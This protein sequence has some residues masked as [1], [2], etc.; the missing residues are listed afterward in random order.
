MKLQDLLAETAQKF[1]SCG[2][3]SAQADA[4]I[5]LSF[6]LQ[7]ARGDLLARAITGAEI[8]ET[9]LRRFL[10]L[11]ERRSARE[12]LQHLTGVA[13]FRKLE[14]KVGP[15]VFVPRFETE[16]VVERALELL[17]ESTAD[18]PI[19]VDL[20]TGSGAI[21]LAIAVERPNARVFAVELSE[22][23]LQY[24]R[25]NFVKYA[26][27]ALLTQGDLAEAFPNLLGQVDLLISNPP[28][29]PNDMIPIYPEVHLHDPALALYGGMDGLDM[30]RKVAARALQLVKPGGKLVIEHADMQGAAAREVLLEMGWQ[31]VTTGKDLAGRDRMVSARR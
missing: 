27:H 12:P 19:V 25:A 8:Q 24:T 9:E 10:E 23:A 5:L 20:A 17:A 30:I 15:G 3:E 14:L 6:T 26:P 31:N 18:E 28:Y 13:Y 7:L 2:I 29:I 11:A 16:V 21:A 22:D 4:E 1:S